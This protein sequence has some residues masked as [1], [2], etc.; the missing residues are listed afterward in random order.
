M[1]DDPTIVMVLGGSALALAVLTGWLVHLGWRGW[2]RRVARRRSQAAF[3]A[4]LK[5]DAAWATVCEF[6]YHG[7]DLLQLLA[8]HGLVD[9]DET[10]TLLTAAEQRAWDEFGERDKPGRESTG[11]GNGAVDKTIDDKIPF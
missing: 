10:D 7:A 6:P 5:T 8:K 1:I 11:H 2:R 3:I 9:Q 4:E